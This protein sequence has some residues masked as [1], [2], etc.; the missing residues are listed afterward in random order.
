MRKMRVSKL[1]IA[2]FVLSVILL[3]ALNALG[4]IA[5]KKLIEENEE[6]REQLGNE[7]EESGEGSD[8]DV[9][10]NDFRKND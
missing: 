7:Q 8:D 4:E 5:L 2:L 1:F 10:L 6:L 9:F 3:V